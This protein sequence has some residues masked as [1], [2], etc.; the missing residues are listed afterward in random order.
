M[1]FLALSTLHILFFFFFTYAFKKKLYIY[2]WGLV[3]LLTHWIEIFTFEIWKNMLHYTIMCYK[4]YVQ[5]SLIS[6]TICIQI[7]ANHFYRKCVYT[8]NE[9]L[10]ITYIKIWLKKLQ[11]N[12]SLVKKRIKKSK[13]LSSVQFRSF[14]YFYIFIF[15][16]VRSSTTA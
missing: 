6:W 7:A 9:L 8:E 5:F 3:L 2:Y 4:V 12:S 11:E 10:A 14:F 13:Y 16:P 15:L 1:M